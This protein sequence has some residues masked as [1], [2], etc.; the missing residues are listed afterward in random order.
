MP[1]VFWRTPHRTILE[2]M[3]VSH[4]EIH[5]DWQLP[6][7]FRV[8]T[9]RLDLVPSSPDLVNTGWQDRSQLSEILGA[10]VPGHWPPELVLD[11]AAPEGAGWWNWYFVKRDANEAVLIGV[12]GVKG[13]PAVTQSV[14]LGCTFLPEFQA[15]G[16]GKE[17]VHALTSWALSQPRIRSVEAEVPEGN[18]ASIAVLRNLGFTETGHDAGLLRFA[19]Q[20][21]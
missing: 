7:D 1:P 3:T 13:W 15:Q 12:G 5:I 9:E 11:S 21:D 14:Q 6:E 10:R 16:Y 4:G 19:K 17:A 18:A 2:S 8:R 20:R